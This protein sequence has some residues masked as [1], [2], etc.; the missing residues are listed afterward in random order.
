MG[1]ELIQAEIKHLT[2][3]MKIEKECF[4][5]CIQESKETFEARLRS[6]NK[7]F[8]MFRDS[9]TDKIMGY[10]SAEFIKDIPKNDEKRADLYVLKLAKF[11]ALNHTPQSDQGAA[12]YISSFALTKEYQG[13]GYGR[14]TWNKAIEEFSII[15]GL[16]KFVLLV[17]RKWESAR[18]IYETTGFNT[19]C[20]LPD[21]FANEDKT[22]EDAL[23]MVKKIET[24]E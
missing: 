20:V 14:I 8:F 18:Y 17:N 16:K 22:K 12:L 1:I 23:V 21:F 4:I 7:Q 13:K 24:F 19:V 2:D 10:I 15:R 11:F 3:I 9:E 5:P 6:K